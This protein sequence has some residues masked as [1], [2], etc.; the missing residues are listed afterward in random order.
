MLPTKK[1]AFAVNNLLSFAQ[2]L[3]ALPNILLFQQFPTIR[4]FARWDHLTFF[5]EKNE[6]SAKYFVYTKK[7]V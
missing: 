4:H 6:P 5:L 2:L 3:L 7:N 1:G